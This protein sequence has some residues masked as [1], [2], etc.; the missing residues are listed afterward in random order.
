MEIMRQYSS[1]LQE[2]KA[3][4]G[5]TSS[6]DAMIEVLQSF[7]SDAVL[8][9]VRPGELQ[10]E[11]DGIRFKGFAGNSE[12]DDWIKTGKDSKTNSPESNL[13]RV[14]FSVL[15]EWRG[16][17]EQENILK[18]SKALYSFF[19]RELNKKKKDA[20]MDE[21]KEF[22]HFQANRQMKLLL[23]NKFLYQLLNTDSKAVEEIISHSL[24]KD[25]LNR[26][27]TA[28][29]N[30]DPE[31]QQKRKARRILD[32]QVS[33]HRHLFARSNYDTVTPN[34]FENAG[35]KKGLMVLGSMFVDFVSNRED[36]QNLLHILRGITDLRGEIQTPYLKAVVLLKPKSAEGPIFSK[37]PFVDR[38]LRFII[39]LFHIPKAS[40]IKCFGKQLVAEGVNYMNQIP[41][42]TKKWNKTHMPI[43]RISTVVSAMISSAWLK[44][45][46]LIGPIIYPTA[47]GDIVSPSKN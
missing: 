40:L 10:C 44:I 4:A 6:I 9:D 17:G 23:W 25:T 42:S 28:E 16:K 39:R 15:E 43:K 26:E 27:E 11:P 19:S 1:L 2:R 37:P 36:Y 18:D 5:G 34:L 14:L 29:S 21:Y 30:I 32:I 20:T 3:I 13:S 22:T 45:I 7:R 24:D 41:D 12:V 47:Y 46:R 31:D 38:D 33:V 8:A 35:K